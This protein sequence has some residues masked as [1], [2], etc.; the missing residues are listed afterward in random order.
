MPIKNLSAHKHFWFS[1]ALAWTLLIAV[2]CLVSFKKLPSVAALPSADKYVHSIFHF[3]FTLLWYLHFRR[4]HNAKFLLV[5]MFLGSLFY[6]SLIELMQHWFTATRKA[7]LNDI[8]ANS[9]GATLAVILIVLY[10]RYFKK[11][12]L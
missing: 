12:G 11:N 3:V 5:K 7:D 2:L 10:G 9:F 4:I 6:G 8:A 1:L